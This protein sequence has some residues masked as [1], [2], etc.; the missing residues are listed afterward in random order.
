M[1]VTTRAMSFL[2]LLMF[3]TSFLTTPHWAPPAILESSYLRSKSVCLSLSASCFLSSFGLSCGILCFL[4]FDVFLE[5]EVRRKRVLQ[6]DLDL[7]AV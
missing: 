3:P 4:L 7:D 2:S 6:G 5:Q 1:T